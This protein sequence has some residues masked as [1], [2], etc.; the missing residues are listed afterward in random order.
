M[1]P[2][3]IFKIMFSFFDFSL[4]VCHFYILIVDVLLIV[5]MGMEGVVGEMLVDCLICFVFFF[6]FHFFLL[7]W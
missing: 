6:F 4:V 5:L 2:M 7:G 3:L 1:E